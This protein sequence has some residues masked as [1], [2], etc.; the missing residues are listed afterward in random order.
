MWITFAS[1]NAI[2]RHV[3][4]RLICHSTPAQVHPWAIIEAV[5]KQGDV[6]AEML[7]PN[8]ESGSNLNIEP[9]FGIADAVETSQSIGH[10]RR[11]SRAQCD[12]LLFKSHRNY[13]L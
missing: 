2:F 4:A 11:L 5:P 6:I 8:I 3:Y 1:T 12:Q 10:A 7:D 13:G 9:G